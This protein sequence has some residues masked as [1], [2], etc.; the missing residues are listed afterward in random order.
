[1][2][3]LRDIGILSQFD[4]RSLPNLKAWYGDYVNGGTRRITLSNGANVTQWDDL[5]GNALHI[6]HV[7]G[8]TP[9][10][11]TAGNYVNSN[12]GALYNFSRAILSGNE[13]RTI[14]WVGQIPQTNQNVHLCLIGYGGG[15]STAYGWSNVYQN[16]Q[17][18]YVD[19]G[20]G[21]WY[22]TAPTTI[23][24]NQPYLFVTGHP[25]SGAFLTGLIHR[26]NGQDVTV[27]ASRDS[28]NDTKNG[29]IVCGNMNSTT[30]FR[31][32]YANHFREFIIYNRLLST[33]EI[34]KV[35]LYLKNKYSIY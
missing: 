28:T 8:T 23:V 29:I 35:E 6:D 12:T 32:S 13:A 30:V 33:D 34:I 2:G 24:V 3:L 18:D 5:S 10:Y 22:G 20:Y 21:Y 14:F 11:V 15:A 1:M 7:S 31:D 19:D 17:I 26:H 4:P 25:S 16:S 27:T 9:T